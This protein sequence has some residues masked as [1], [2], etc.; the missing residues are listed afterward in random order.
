M[1]EQVRLELQRQLQAQREQYAERL[2]QELPELAGLAAR[3]EQQAGLASGR[4]R[5]QALRERLHRIAG[6]AGTFGFGHL[7]NRARALEQRIDRWLDSQKPSGQ[8]LAALAR[9]IRQFA[10]QLPE[11]DSELSQPAA[12]EPDEELSSRCRVFFLESQPDAAQASAQALRNFGY[13]VCHSADRQALL[14][15]IDRQ[16]P[17]ALVVSVREAEDLAAIAA[18]QQRLET[19]LPLLVIHDRFDFASQLAAVR[20]GAQ[21][22]FVRPLDVTLLETGLERCLNRPQ[23]DPY[24]VMIVDDDADLAERYSLVL[25][26]SQMHT[27]VVSEPAQALDVMQAFNPEVLLLDVNMPGCSGPELAQII[28]L[29]DEWLRVPIIYLSAETD[30]GRQMAALLKAG[31]DFITKPISDSQLIASV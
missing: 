1:G 29:R 11:P 9:S 21:G 22:Y 31:D 27:R 13:E 30:I 16:P 24:R 2:G 6:A 5:V 15:A 4:Q 23:H 18:L 7:G 3:L 10:S 28:R 26:N 19:P 25:Q 8:A 14:A 20:A 12:T 17:D